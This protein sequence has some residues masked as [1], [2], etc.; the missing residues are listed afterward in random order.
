MKRRATVLAATALVA[1]GCG[2]ASAP[3]PAP[4]A[5]TIFEVRKGILR[6]VI[7]HIPRTTAVAEAALS[8]LDVHAPVKVENGTAHVQ[9]ARATDAQTASIVYTLTQVSTIRRVDV[10]GRRGLTRADFATYVPPILVETPAPTAKVNRTFHVSGTASVFEATVVVEARRGGR[11]L[12]RRSVTASEG[13]P[14]RG[15]FDTTLTV[16]PGALTVQ[17]FA[18][19]AAD[20]RPQHEVDVAVQVAG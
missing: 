10:A 18:P 14:G 20:G 1:V 5:L 4:M 3:P 17:V 2:S 19:S 7:V 13:A 12:Q 6:P 9:L 15:S 16:A 8:A 11:V